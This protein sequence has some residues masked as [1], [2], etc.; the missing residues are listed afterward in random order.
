MKSIRIFVIALCCAL[1]F[2]FNVSAEGTYYPIQLLTANYQ[3]TVIEEWDSSGLPP[4][5]INFND[6]AHFGAY[7]DL[8]LTIDA[9][10]V[11]N[12]EIY[13]N[14]YYINNYYTDDVKYIRSNPQII[15]SFKWTEDQLSQYV[16]ID[17]SI[18]SDLHTVNY[19]FTFNTKDIPDSYKNKYFYFFA[20]ANNYTGTQA[21]NFKSATAYIIEDPELTEMEKILQGIDTII[22]NQG[23]I[24]NDIST[25][26]STTN[27]INNNIINIIQYGSNYNQIDQTII[28]GLGSAE[29]QLSNA[30]DAIQNKSKT[31]VNKV[32]SQWTANKGVASSFLT[33]ISP[34]TSAI[35]T[36]TDNFFDAIPEEIKNAV[37]TIMLIV[38][39]GW[40][41]GRVEG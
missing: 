35:G 9:T 34:A 10:Y 23:N 33:T 17:Y 31:L 39:I 36:V 13:S 2:S 37:I 32:A 30:E 21:V 1:I 38:F 20:L 16:T 7:I 18:S 29:D 15:S 26:I 22:E 25:L 6:N 24:S 14:A 41:I 19:I 5:E 40:L 28:N 3:G 27:Q 8:P 4:L 11:I 12:V